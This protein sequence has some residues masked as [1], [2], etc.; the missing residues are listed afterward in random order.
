MFRNTIQIRAIDS[1]NVQLGLAQKAAGIEPTDEVLYEGVLTYGE[2][3]HRRGTWD[4]KRQTEGLDAVWYEGAELMLFP[5]EV[6][7]LGEQRFR[8]LGGRP[9]RAKGIGIDTAEGG[10]RSAMSAVDELGIIELVSKKTPDTNVI[11]GEVIAFARKHGLIDEPQRW[12]FDRGGGGKQH[13]DRLRAMG[14]N[15]RTVAFGEAITL[16]P[17]RSKRLFP[18]KMEQKEDKYVYKNRR[19]ELF[20]ELHLAF[21]SP[22]GFAM[23]TNTEA[24][25]R[26]RWQLSK[27]PKLTDDEGRYWMLPKSPPP[28]SA[29]PDTVDCLIKRIG[30]SPDEADSVSLANW[31]MNHRPSVSRV[32]GGTS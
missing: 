17:K 12:C 8:E 1:P 31:A 23:P 22:L 25:M 7:L 20:F 13:A 10:D 30:Y 16:D 18:E 19:A 32:G 11:P 5:P 28:K 15:V 4:K 29:N 9:R 2:Y 6:L 24:G 14:H 21:S 27:I 26:L 3:C